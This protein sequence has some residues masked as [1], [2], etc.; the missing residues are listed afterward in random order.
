MSVSE[1][2]LFRKELSAGRHADAE[3]MLD[4]LRASGGDSFAYQNV[5]IYAQWGDTAKA[6][7]WLDTAMRLRDPGLEYLKADP[8]LDPLR[9]EPRFEAIE[10]TLK[11]PN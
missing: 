1:V 2:N 8:G 9:K 7:N 6:L 11:F 5:E 3:A 4:K 10:R